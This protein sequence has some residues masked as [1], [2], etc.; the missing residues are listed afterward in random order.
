M[1]V[2]PEEL[3]DLMKREGPRPFRLVDVREEEE[4]NI[5]R[6]EW[7]ELIPLGKLAQEAPIRLIDKDKPVVVYCHHGMRSAYA[8]DYL[9]NLG[10]E[11]V[12]NLTGGIDAWSDLVDPYIPR[13]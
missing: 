3:N 12:Y 10:Y 5:C 2:S 9:R 11:H 8:A 6:L 7:A 4:F 13:Y 1:E